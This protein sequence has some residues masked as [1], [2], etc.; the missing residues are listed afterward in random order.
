[1]AEK[2]IGEGSIK[3]YAN[4]RL[5]CRLETRDFCKSS[6]Y[7]PI[8]ER[9]WSSSRP[10]DLG[11]P[12]ENISKWLCTYINFIFRNVQLDL[13]KLIPGHLFPEVTDNDTSLSVC[14]FFFLCW[15]CL[16]SVIEVLLITKATCP[17]ISRIMMY[18]VAWETPVTEICLKEFF[19][20]SRKTRI[21]GS[22]RE[23]SP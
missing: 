8:G 13:I 7:V 2:R 11:R 19:P 12:N 22:D 16:Q 3:D 5:I 23:G 20:S 21:H 6:F 4:H 9:D 14:F 18:F 15:K 17:S 10:D 1:M